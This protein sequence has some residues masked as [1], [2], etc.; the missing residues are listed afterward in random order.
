MRF[1][2]VAIALVLAL[3]PVHTAEA[4]EPSALTVMFTDRAGAPAQRAVVT[5][6]NPVTNDY[7]YAESDGG[8]A[9]IDAPPGEYM[10]WAKVYTGQSDVSMLMW[11]HFTVTGQATVTLDARM[12]RPIEVTVPHRSARIAAV[13]VGAN[14]KWTFNGEARGAFDSVTTADAPRVSTA[15]LGPGHDGVHTRIKVQMTAPDTAYHLQ[16]ERRGGMFTGLRETVRA[17]DV[18]GVRVDYAALGDA[19]EAQVGA[20]VTSQDGVEQGL[21]VPIPLP[22]SRMEY[23]G[24]NAVWDTLVCFGEQTQSCLSGPPSPRWNYAPFLPTARL[25]ER[26]DNRLRIIAGIADQSGHPGLAEDD[27]RD[28]RFTLYRDGVKVAE[29]PLGESSFTDLP[30]EK[31]RYRIEFDGSFATL[32]PGTFHAAWTFESGFMPIGEGEL[33]A[34]NVRFTPRLDPN[35]HAQAGRPLTLPIEVTGGT[36]RTLTVDVSYDAGATWVAAPL[37]P[38]RTG[39]GTRITPPA[40][41]ADISLRA[42]ATDA[43]GNEVEQVMT[44]AIPLR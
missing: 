7:L 20:T 43:A 38:T 8:A 2:A 22:H 10:L 3:L 17:E 31:A 37:Q 1:R 32:L 33:P 30:P 44:R 23:Y 26:L 18:T 40:G 36:A 12:A 41:A 25:I 42:H 29:T 39:W 21:G 6:V 14:M 15:Q 9:T 13:V 11:P 35:N 28:G 19:R 16:W 24:K 5:M 4:T 34:L 27:I